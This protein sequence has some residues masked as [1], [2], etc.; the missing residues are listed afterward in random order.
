[1]TFSENLVSIIIKVLS[2][3]RV[4][5]TEVEDLIASERLFL[6][7]YLNKRK[8]ISDRDFNRIS[9]FLNS[10]DKIC[11]LLQRCPGYSNFNRS[12]L[13]ETI[14]NRVV[15]KVFLEWLDSKNFE[16]SNG[17]FVLRR[18]PLSNK[19]INRMFWRETLAPQMRLCTPNAPFFDRLFRCIRGSVQIDKKAK[20]RRI[21][22]KQKYASIKQPKYLNIFLKKRL[23][24]TILKLIS[25]NMTF[26]KHFRQTQLDVLEQYDSKWRAPFP[27]RGTCDKFQLNLRQSIRK[28]LAMM[29]SWFRKNGHRFSHV[30]ASSLKVVLRQVACPVTRAD[31]MQVFSMLQACTNS[32]VTAKDGK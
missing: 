25:P 1:M 16:I 23:R 17:E 5:K 30:D 29:L 21:S 15:R 27:D 22:K 7:I 3:E 28:A 32:R 26:A 14:L 20:T 11:T 19:D 4:L 13:A 24:E 9:I 10:A 18:R 31:Q 12:G 2:A 6:F 8:L